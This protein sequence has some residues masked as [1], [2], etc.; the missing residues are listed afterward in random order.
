[1][2]HVVAKVP[3]C[4]YVLTM[5]IMLRAY[6]KRHRRLLKPLCTLAYECLTDYLRA[7]ADCHNGVPGIILKLH[8]YGEYLNFHPHIHA[9]VADGLFMRQPPA[10]A[11]EG[12]TTPVPA[13]P[14]S[15]GFVSLPEARPVKPLEELFRARVIKL[16]VAEKLLSPEQVKI[17]DSWK[18]TGFSAHASK[19]IPPGATMDLEALA[20]YVLRNSFSIEKI[21]QKSPDDPIIYRS[22]S[23]ERI[24]ANFQS[25]TPIEFL[26][27]V[28]QHIPEKGSQSVRYLGYYSNKACGMR[29][30][31]LPAEL[32]VRDPGVS[33]ERSS[34]KWR[35][36]ILRV[37]HVDPL[38]C[39]VCQ[40][41]MR[42]IA[43]IE[44]REI[45]ERILRHQGA[46]HD[47]PAGLPPPGASEPYTFEPCQDVD[48]MP[49]YESAPFD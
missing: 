16:L 14:T 42:I 4:H 35:D 27:E 17:L 31:S 7:A 13:G 37:W 23:N 40:H 33:A 30:R 39:P 34:R 24:N 1:M 38:R 32:V 19:K 3:H 5:P 2:D 29:R 47:P 15:I 11:I 21:I 18:R 12:A 46:W 10:A 36:L 9:L 43:I 26:A 25:F 6:F 48:P 49:D 22:N 44:D 20:Q 28:T 41:P 8:T 45:V